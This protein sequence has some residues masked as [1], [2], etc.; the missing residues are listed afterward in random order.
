MRMRMRGMRIMDYGLW[1][2]D[3]G[4]PVCGMMRGD[5]V[6]VGHS[7]AGIVLAC[8]GSLVHTAVQ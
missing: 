8:T 5:K 3:Y 7:T 6:C 2:M 1:I 4:I